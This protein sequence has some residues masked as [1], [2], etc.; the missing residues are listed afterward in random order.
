MGADP[1]MEAN[2]NFT[3]RDGTSKQ[4]AEILF[5]QAFD[6]MPG[7]WQKSISEMTKS[8]T[9]SLHVPQ[10][11][12]FDPKQA[13]W[14]N[15]WNAGWALQQ[16]MSDTFA[17]NGRPE[18]L[19]EGTHKNMDGSSYSVSDGKITSFTTANG[20]T[21]KDI[22]Y[23]KDNVVESMTMP[24]GSRLEPRYTDLRG[25]DGQQHHIQTG[26][27]LTRPGG[28]GIDAGFQAARVTSNGLMTTDYRNS[29]YPNVKM[30]ALNGM[31][32]E[33][34]YGHNGTHIISEFRQG[35]GPALYFNSKVNPDTGRI[36]PRL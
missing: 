21:Y 11:E 32:G 20:E 3:H 19:T 28:E 1:P 30:T 17:Q 5:N 18:T 25:S 31:A 15:E 7:S 9:D 34:R 23:S 29:N 8:I 2:P 4:T 22:T 24:D 6:S 16:H 26:Y 36:V 35:D 13:D 10:L 33:M 14:R 27:N 12:L